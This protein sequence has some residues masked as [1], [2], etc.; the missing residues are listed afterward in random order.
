MMLNRIFT[1]LAGYFERR[2]ERGQSRRDERYLAK[3]TDLADLEQR[4]RALARG[5]VHIPSYG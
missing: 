5:R 2:V 3:A 1:N 4:Q